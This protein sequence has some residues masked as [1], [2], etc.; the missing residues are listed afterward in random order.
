M[1]E[2][3][4]THEQLS[5]IAVAFREHANRNPRAQMYSR[6]LTLADCA[7][8]PLISSPLRRYDCCLQTDGAVAFVV[9][10]PER[11]KALRRPP[12]YVKDAGQ[13]S[14][15]GHRGPLWGI[16]HR[17]DLVETPSRTLAQRMYRRTGIRADTI[18]VAQIYD[19]FTI[20]ALIQLEEYGFCAK[21]EGGQFAASGALSLGGRLPV[22]TAGGNLSEGYLHGVNHILEG[23]R[24]LRGESTSQ[25][26]GAEVCL[27]TAGTPTPTS[28][29]ILGRELG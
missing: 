28:A 23:V 16:L 7:E 19:C 1:H 2:F 5:N 6:Q 4:T 22:N 24:Q 17:P 8:A 13:S 18:D 9:T 26:E 15:S 3:G 10:T 21:G 29:T 20:T 12:V 11:A 14:L 25:V 27:V